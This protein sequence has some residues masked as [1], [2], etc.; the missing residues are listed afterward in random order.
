LQGVQFALNGKIPKKLAL[1]KLPKCTGCL[2]GVMTKIPWCGK[3]SKCS[4]NVFAATKPG[5]M[6]SVDQMVSTKVGF[7]AKHV[8]EKFA[9]E[10]GVHTHHY[11]WDNGL[12]A[13][14]AFKES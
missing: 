10:H 7:F 6:V 4:H 12:Y 8:F 13:N 2:F 14:N 1:I 9:V 3:E 11:H 5:E